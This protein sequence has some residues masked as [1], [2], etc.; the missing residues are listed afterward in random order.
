[1]SSHHQKIEKSEFVLYDD[2]KNGLK[3]QYGQHLT[4]WVDNTIEVVANALDK[5]T[6]SANTNTTN[7]KSQ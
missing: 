2:E 1:M 3:I 4:P 6:S 7:L 5:M